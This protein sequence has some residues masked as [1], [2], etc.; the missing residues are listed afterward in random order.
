MTILEGGGDQRHAQAAF[1]CGKDPVTI[2]QEAGWAQ[3]RSIHVQKISTQPEFDPRT[4]Q[5]VASRYND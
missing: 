4:V 3:G 5:P 1:Y 2:V